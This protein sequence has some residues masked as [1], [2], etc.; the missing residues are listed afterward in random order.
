MLLGDIRKQAEQAR[1]LHSSNAFASVLPTGSGL[2]LLPWLPLVDCDLGYVNQRNNFLPKMLLA[3]FF[4]TAI[5]TKPRCSLCLLV[6]ASF[7]SSPVAY[8]LTSPFRLSMLS[9]SQSQEDPAL[10]WTENLSQLKYLQRK[11]DHASQYCPC[12]S[13]EERRF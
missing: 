2:E 9:T 3:M 1:K 7:G 6:I 12:C 4:I 11:R 10:K 8:S 13:L 5:K